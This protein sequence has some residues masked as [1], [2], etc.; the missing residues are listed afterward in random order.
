[1]KKENDEKFFEMLELKHQGAQLKTYRGEK[2]EIVSAHEW[3][4]HNLGYEKYGKQEYAKMTGT[5][6]GDEEMP[7]LNRDFSHCKEAN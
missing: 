5:Q 2:N 3:N 7:Q 6:V 4:R 1:V